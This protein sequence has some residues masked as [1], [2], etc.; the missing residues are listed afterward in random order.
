MPVDAGNGALLRIVLDRAATD[1][2]LIPDGDG[3]VAKL[4]HG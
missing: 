3:K 4:F 2:R 1:L